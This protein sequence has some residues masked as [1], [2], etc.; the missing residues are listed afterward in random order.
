MNLR[1]VLVTTQYRRPKYSQRFFE[2]LAQCYGIEDYTLLISCDYNEQYA[3]DC[4]TVIGMSREFK[5]CETQVHINNPRLGIDVNK[6][7]II[8]KAYEMTDY[9]IFLEDDTIPSKDALRYFEWAAVRFAREPR[10]ISVCGYNR[11]TEIATHNQVLQSQPY[12]VHMGG[13]FCPWG[14]AMWKDRYERKMGDGSAY[15]ERW[16]EEVNGRFDWWFYHGMDAALKE[17]SIY[18]VLPR[19]QSIGGENAEHTPSPEWH[20]ENEY[21]PYGAWSQD[22]PDPAF[23]VWRFIDTLAGEIPERSK[24][25]DWV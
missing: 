24:P 9:M 10:I 6:L 12:E 5:A 2:A 21:N 11:Y 19:V 25:V 8:P 7:F 3:A 14:W 18:P 4:D 17:G 16:G 1:K 23:D 15:A 22:M 13:G 20:Q